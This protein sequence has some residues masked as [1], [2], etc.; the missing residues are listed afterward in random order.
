M[1]KSEKRLRSV[2]S[3][4]RRNALSE[5]TKKIKKLHKSGENENNEKNVAKIPN[6]KNQILEMPTVIRKSHMIKNPENVKL[7]R[8]EGYERKKKKK[9]RD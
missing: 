4:K 9:Q 1:I 2:E 8:R 5:S 3:E 6:R 7:P